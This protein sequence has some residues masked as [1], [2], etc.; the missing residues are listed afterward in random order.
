M[1]YIIA[2]PSYKR[3]KFLKSK[4]LHMLNSYNIDKDIVYIFVADKEEKEIY[5]KELMNEYKNI[6]VGKKGI[7]HIR[8]FMSNYF[9]EG[10]KIVYIDDDIEGVN[11]AINEYNIKEKTFN[12]L[13][14]LSCLGTFITQAFKLSEKTGYGLWAL[15]PRGNPYFMTPNQITTKLKFCMGGFHGVINNRE[16]E[17]RTIGDKEDYERTIKY[18]LKDKGVIR[19]NGVSPITRVYK[20]KGGLQETDR[21]TDSETNSKIL[22]Q[23]YPRLVKINKQRKTGFTEIKLLHSSEDLRNSIFL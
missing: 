14:R 15:Y 6:I 10:Q 3:S 16:A 13:Q 2:I 7:Q 12:K 18:Y 17:V 21:E 11:I 4:T 5:E 9:N 1:D 20:A 23:N 22:L 8:N 19:Y